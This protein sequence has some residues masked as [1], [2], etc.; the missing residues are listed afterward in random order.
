MAGEKI[1]VV[2]DEAINREF[3]SEMLSM[4]GYEV[5][6]SADGIEALDNI[7][8]T[9]FDLVLTDLMMPKL[10]GIALLSQI[11]ELSPQTL[12]IVFTGFVSIESAVK[13]MKAGAFDYITKPL[14]LEEV[15]IA[16]KKAFEFQRLQRENLSLRRQLKK[17]Y[18]FENMIGDSEGIQEVF[19]LIETVADS[20]S[21]ILILGESGTGKELVARAIHYNSQRQNSPLIPVNC[22]AIPESLLES[23]LFGHEKGAFTGAIAARVGRFE[24]AKGGTIFLDEIAEMSPALQV[25]LLRV[26]QE[27][28]FERVGGTKT[29]KINVRIIAATNQDLDEAVAKRTFREDLYYRL[30]VIP[31]KLP[32]LRE[33]KSD[34][35][36][37][38]A[39][40]LEH[41]NLE[42]KK[43]LE[44]IA[45]EAMNIL[46]NYRWPGNVRELENLVERLV[47]LQGKGVVNPVDL[48]EKFRGGGT[49]NQ[50][51]PKIMIPDEGISF[52]EI[53][54]QFERDLILQALN[55][56]KWVKNK[57][58]KLLGLNRTTLVEK[59]KKIGLDISAPF[60]KS[61]P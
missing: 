34:V 15:K 5:I 30:N 10:D 51:T 37:L 45:P 35:P 38:F 49:N 25:K 59:I 50:D 41:F 54:E 1:L 3:L 31:I 44:G 29:I 43:K 32:P 21:N 61:W 19:H 58:A 17:K 11:K 40:F 9:N 47:I 2:D 28:E 56:T 6:T 27:H 8:E 60:G 48:P 20:D 39:H 52:R 7:K 36:L 18:F 42:K 12:G 46:I 13:A 24:L 23:E 26:L 53:T 55:R 57:A 14:Q 33:R 22:G 4:E 16:I